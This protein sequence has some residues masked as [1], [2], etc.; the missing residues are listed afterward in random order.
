MICSGLVIRVSLCTSMDST[1]QKCQEIGVD[2]RR[3]DY[4][5]K[6]ACVSIDIV[7]DEDWSE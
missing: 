4:G 2:I 6:I 5:G 7:P 1:I 3:F